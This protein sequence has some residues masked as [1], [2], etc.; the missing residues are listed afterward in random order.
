MTGRGLRGRRAARRILVAAMMIDVVLALLVVA[1]PNNMRGPLR[2]VPSSP[3]W[4]IPAV[5]VALNLAGLVWM[6]RIVR[7][8]PEAHRSWWRSNRW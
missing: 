1:A 2:S 4:L 3:L 8:D 6:I 5:G 7:A